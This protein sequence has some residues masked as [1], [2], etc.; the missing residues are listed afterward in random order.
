MENLTWTC[1][2][3]G[4]VRPDAKI[5]VLTKPMIIKGRNCGEQNIRYCNDS[6]ACLKGAREFDL[7]KSEEAEG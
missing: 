5:S 3:C 1:L 7:L 6:P 2:I 4:R